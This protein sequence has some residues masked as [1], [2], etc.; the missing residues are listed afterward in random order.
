MKILLHTTAGIVLGFGSVLQ[1][2][3]ETPGP[4]PDYNTL[5]GGDSDKAWAFWL[6][7]YVGHSDNVQLLPDFPLT[8]IDRDSGYLGVTAQGSYQFWENGN[9]TAG[10]A[11]RYDQTF[12]FESS[13]GA[14]APD[15]F[16][17]TVFEPALYLNYTSG[18][19][20]GRVSYSYRWEDAETQLIGASSHNLGIMVGHEINPCLDLQIGWTHGWDE[21][22][23][24]AS[25]V[26]DRDAERDRYSASLVFQPHENGT[27]VIF[28]Y[29]YLDN[30]ADGS[31]FRYDG[32]EYTVRL[33]Q[34]LTA[35][36]GMV[37]Y[38]GYTDLDYSSGL[39]RE[40]EFVRAGLQFI[41]VIDEHWS[42]DIYYSHLDI[43]S[44]ASVFEGS[45]NNFGVGIRYD[46]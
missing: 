23:T 39:R 3:V 44:N 6:R 38:V 25:G 35:N 1:A 42:A 7:T 21:Y 28:S 31:V 43:D 14:T 46:F 27:R 4:G 15:K 13:G 20:Y 5:I 11:F 24:R 37:A 12:H 40:L 2:D 9:F 10:T 8:S 22:H 45:R 17:L 18:D 34:P 32:H 36:I 26:F 19:C 30:D 16:D 41:Y 29:A 33:Q